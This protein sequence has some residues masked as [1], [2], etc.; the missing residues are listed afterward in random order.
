MSLSPPGP[1]AGCYRASAEAL[2]VVR[3]RISFELQSPRSGS[4][5]LQRHRAAIWR[6]SCLVHGWLMELVTN[7]HRMDPSPFGPELLGDG[8]DEQMQRRCEAIANQLPISSITLALIEQWREY[9]RE[10]SEPEW[11]AAST[12]GEKT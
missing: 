9:S 5:R 10:P 7:L 8:E 1:D 6:C 11:L 4:A 3:Q 2:Q 12:S